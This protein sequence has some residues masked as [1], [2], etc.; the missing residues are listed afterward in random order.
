MNSYGSISS[1]MHSTR[2]APRPPRAPASLAFY[3]IWTDWVVVAVAFGSPHKTW[4]LLALP[5]SLV[6]ALRQWRLHPICKLHDVGHCA[7]SH[8]RSPRKKGPQS[9]AQR[10]VNGTWRASPVRHSIDPID[11][12]HFHISIYM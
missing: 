12:T 9:R 10:D 4:L 3:P 7:R 8:W 6:A 1:C 11:F 2:L 5:P